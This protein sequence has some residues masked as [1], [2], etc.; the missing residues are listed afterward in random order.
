VDSASDPVWV[1]SIGSPRA[2]WAAGEA[3]TIRTVLT[4]VGPG[5]G[6]EYFG[7]SSGPIAFD[8][9]E[10]DGPR[11]LEGGML[12]D[13]KMHEMRSDEPLVLGRFKAGGYSSDDPHAAFYEGLQDDPLLRLPSG[14][15][16]LTARAVFSMPPDCSGRTVSLMASIVLTVE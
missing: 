13:C 11:H 12:S 4:Y 7:S 10:I 16:E 5:G 2:R 9:K 14:R 1:L 6:T 15:W 3:I 8:L